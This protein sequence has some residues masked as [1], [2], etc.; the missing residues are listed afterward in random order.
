M[1]LVTLLEAQNY[2]VHNI[3]LVILQGAKTLKDQNMSTFQPSN[4][5][6]LVCIFFAVTRRVIVN[7]V[8]SFLK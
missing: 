1:F 7:K 3:S 5:E 6:I 4:S 2:M 8:F